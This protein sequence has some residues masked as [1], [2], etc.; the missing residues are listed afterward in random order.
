[1]QHNAHLCPLCCSAH[2][3]ILLDQNKAVEAADAYQEA[4]ELDAA[5]AVLLMLARTSLLWPPSSPQQLLPAFWQPKA[6]K[7]AA[8]QLQQVLDLLQQA[9]AMA[10]QGS[11]AALALAG[12]SNPM[13][14]AVLQQQAEV[15][16]QLGVSGCNSI[17]MLELLW[18]ICWELP[19]TPTNVNSSS[20]TAISSSSSGNACGRSYVL[21]SI[22]AAAAV[23]LLM[24]SLRVHLQLRPAPAGKQ[25]Q[26]QQQQQQQILVAGSSATVTVTTAI[27][28]LLLWFQRHQDAS[29][30][31]QSQLLLLSQDYSCTTAAAATTS[32]QQ[33][34]AMWGLLGLKPSNTQLPGVL[35]VEAPGRSHLHGW[36]PVTA[37]VRQHSTASPQVQMATAAKA[38]MEKL[39]RPR[40][41]KQATRVVAMLQQVQS[42]TASIA[43][44]WPP[45]AAQAGMP[46][47][48]VS[49]CSGL[50]QTRRGATSIASYTSSSSSKPSNANTTSSSSSSTGNFTGTPGDLQF[51]VALAQWQAVTLLQQQQLLPQGFALRDS[52][53]ALFYSSIPL[54]PSVTCSPQLLQELQKA[55]SQA[56]LTAA[57]DQ[58]LARA[59]DLTCTPSASGASAKGAAAAAAA[60]NSRIQSPQSIWQQW[61]QQQQQQWQQP[62]QQQQQQVSLKCLPCSP[63]YTPD[64]ALLLL[65]LQPLLLQ[66]LFGQLARRSQV[67]PTLP[68]LEHA[69]QQA[70]IPPHVAA[71]LRSLWVASSWM[72][73]ALVMDP[74][75]WTPT[76]GQQLQRPHYDYICALV[77]AARA[78]V[79]AVASSSSIQGTAHSPAAAA[80]VGVMKGGHSTTS[81]VEPQAVRAA[82]MA[83][84]HPLLLLHLLERSCVAV[85]AVSTRLHNTVLPESLV[86]SC[87]AGEGQQQLYSWLRVT[88][89]SQIQKQ[90]LQVGQGGSLKVCC[91]EG[92]IEFVTHVAE[93]LL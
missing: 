49:S 29:L 4:G 41:V 27:Q 26:P 10:A 92:C 44:V 24:D 53:N 78:L 17:V 73:Y 38:A 36:L 2:E 22:I 74:L 93:T 66:G 52:A 79:S 56:A 40:L 55:P 71:A 47:G 85:C 58:L 72:Q 5:A 3:Q 34:L 89:I 60:D 59:I 39:L 42:A 62:Q 43:A 83:Q 61:Q 8:K 37:M 51:L 33:Q 54:A 7:A 31:L 15:L 64:N 50:K 16:L 65:L 63:H 25:Q 32:E 81:M 86:L 46:A 30:G 90:R 19:A 87:M 48:Q 9:D 82:E 21:A 84:V 75:A 67:P 35:V 91:F 28:Q 57:I 76:P 20:S 45:S 80:G 68:A 77:S 70:R 11:S 13:V 23:D 6:S 14:R 18:G 69:A 12:G 88:N 1:M